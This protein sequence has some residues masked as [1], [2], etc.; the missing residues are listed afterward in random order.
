MKLLFGDVFCLSFFIFQFF[1][2]KNQQFF[3]FHWF[4]QVRVCS[5]IKCFDATKKNVP[6]KGKRY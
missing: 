1:F 4:H 2:D 3:G 6:A 5:F